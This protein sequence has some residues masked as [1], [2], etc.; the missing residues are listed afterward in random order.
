MRTSIAT[1]SLSG[2]LTE[3]LTAAARAGFD[4]VE[5]FENDLLAAP[6]SP[7]EVRA[8]C[9]DLGL[10]V[11]LYQPLRDIEAVPAEV[12]ARNL[13]RAR[14]KFDLMRR[15]GADTVLVC[16][17]V[18]P[19]A[20]D[21]DALA[22]GQ[23]SEL[24]GLAADFGIRVA[25]EALAWGRHV[26]TYD[27]AWRIVEAADHPA[28]GTCLDSFHILSRGCDPE[29]IEDIPGEKIFFLQLADAPLPAMDVLQWSRHHRCFPGQG[30]FDVAGLVRHVLRTGYDGPLSLE[31]FNDV[32]RQSEAGPTAVDARRSLLMLQEEVGA[33]GPPAPVVPT[34]FAFA[35]L[36]TP[37]AEPLAALLGALGFARTARHRGKPVDLWQQGEAR[38]LVN[39][40]AAVRRDGTRLAAVGLES[41][42]PAGAARRAEA[43]LAPVLPRR[44]APGDAPLDAVAAPDGTELFFCGT[45]PDG[46]RA[47]FEDVE[48][49]PA[50]PGVRHIDHL[51]LT[52]PWHHFDEAALFH[53]SVLGLRAEDSVDVAD[54]YGLLRSRAVSNADGSVRIA[55]TV[56]A[57]PTDDTVHAQHIALATDDVVAAARRFR[58]AGG[59]LLPI[60]AN[61]HDDLAARHDFADGEL[62]TYREVGILYDRDEHGALRHCYTRTIGGVFFELLQRDPGH[63]GY[64]AR[65][66]P[67]RL[68]AQH[69]ARTHAGG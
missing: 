34:G 68:A 64:G 7:E 58:D 10:T 67:V 1:V 24:A 8:R 2:S 25:Y 63:R 30:G 15:L 52:Q 21:D 65:N 55:L 53:R 42:D 46:W 22:A 26:S 38:I 5:I 39:T 49:A 57:A 33:A 62:D 43:L 12:F 48:H 45:R 17:S 47:D 51:A 18:D 36:L 31:V 56:G 44:R 16:S 14:H 66:A 41:P 61:Y 59:R 23:L 69:A 35:E 50:A 19:A 6:L 3:K 28:L 9:A 29:G 37:D 54:P 4:G 40:G 20:V 11:D 27:H 13:R 60:P 32:V